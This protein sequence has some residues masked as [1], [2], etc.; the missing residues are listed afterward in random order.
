MD[1]GNFWV[2]WTNCF[3]VKQLF[4]TY[5]N[6]Y[7]PLSLSVSVSVSGDAE[8]KSAVAYVIG[9]DSVHGISSIAACSEQISFVYLICYALYKTGSMLS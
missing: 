3:D 4:S 2:T 7:L 9:M 5:S 1:R 8:Y 6:Q